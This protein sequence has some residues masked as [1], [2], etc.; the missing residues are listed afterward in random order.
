MPHLTEFPEHY[1][2][3]PEHDQLR[4]S[5]RR[6]VDV[7][8][9]PHIHEWEEAKSFPRE[10]FEDMGTAGFLGLQYP[11]EYG[12]Q[13]GDFAANLILCEELSHVGAESVCTAVSVHTAMA[14]PP[15]LEYGTDKQRSTHLPDLIAGRRIAALAISEPD[16]GS[17][18]AGIRTEARRERGGWVLNGAKTFITNGDRADVVLVIART[19]E[20]DAAKR[21]FSLFLVDTELDGFSRGRRLRETRAPRFGYERPPL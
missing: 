15:I 7:R 9:K 6:W 3:S 19:S 2:F 11:E 12:G 8:I 5:I 17:D 21:R 16:A 13:G 1:L 4:D 10:V 20:R 18:V 14:V